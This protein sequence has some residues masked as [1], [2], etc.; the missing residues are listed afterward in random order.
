M[1]AKPVGAGARFQYRPPAPEVIEATAWL[2][3]ACGRY[4]L[5]LAA[6]ALQ[7]S[8]RDPRVTSTVVGVTSPTR[9]QELI[10]NDQIQIPGEL[11]AEV[12]ERLDLSRPTAA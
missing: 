8:T 6:L 9:V 11:W 1:L 3:E 4:G 2:H 12:E 10:D 7:F 5:P